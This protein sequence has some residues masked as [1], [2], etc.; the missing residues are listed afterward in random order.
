MQ[1]IGEAAVFCAEFG[2]CCDEFGAVEG[3]EQ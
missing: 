2:K 1:A 3:V